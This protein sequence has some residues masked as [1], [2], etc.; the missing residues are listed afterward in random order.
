MEGERVTEE[1]SLTL[2][3][4]ISKGSRHRAGEAVLAFP[5][6]FLSFFVLSFSLSISSFRFASELATSLITGSPAAFHDSTSQKHRYATLPRRTTTTTTTTRLGYVH[7]NAMT[8][9]IPFLLFLFYL[10]Y[11]SKRASLISINRYP[12]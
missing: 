3:V 4:H 1:I 10:C 8:M 12:R 7:N 9:M 5:L 2:N 11:S 6:L